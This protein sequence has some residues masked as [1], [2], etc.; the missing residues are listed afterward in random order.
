MDLK[1]VFRNEETLQSVVEKTKK[2]IAKVINSN[3]ET[4]VQMERTSS[5]GGIGICPICGGNIMEGK[6]NYYCSNYREKNCGFVLWKVVAKK[7][8]SKEQIIQLLE[9]GKTSLIKGFT[10]KAGGTFSACLVLDAEGKVG[11]QFPKRKR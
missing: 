11:F 4:D 7:E 9:K 5:G 2:D 8:L 3:W 1:K 6:K 10:K